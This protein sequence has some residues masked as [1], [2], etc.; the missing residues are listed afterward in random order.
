MTDQAIIKSIQEGE[1]S[2]DNREE[3]RKELLRNP[4]TIV[5]LDDDPTG[6]QTVHNVPVVTQWSEEVIENEVVK[7]PVFFILTNSR[8]LQAEE[9]KA[10]GTLIGQRLKKAA[11]KYDKKLLVISRSDSTLRGH[12]PN[13][14]TA[15]A[16]GLGWTRTKELLIPAFFEG[17]RYTFNDI[18]YVK[19]GEDFI[20]AGETPFA[21]DNTFGYKSSNLKEW[22]AEKTDGAISTNEV[23][24]LGLDLIQNHSI[25]K[26][27]DILNG[28]QHHF[29][30]NATSYNDLSTIAL[31]CLRSKGPFIFRTAASFVNAISGIEVKPLLQKEELFTKTNSTKGLVVVGSYVPKTTAQLTYLKKYSDAFFIELNVTELIKSTSVEK[32]L[33]KISA[34]IDDQIE[35]KKTVVLYTEREVIKGDTKEESLEIVNQVSRN[36]ITIIKNLKNKPGYILAKG[37]ITSS[38]IAVKALKV[39]RANTIGQVIKGVPVWQLG[40]EAKF[41]E[42]PYIIFPGNVGESDSLYNV[43]HKLS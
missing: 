14:V 41:P 25:E 9:A 40:S 28:D 33:R 36:L 31:A 8:A 6:T 1:K 27:C 5:I 3:I 13:E 43:I 29:I 4:R 7:S 16:E 11:V 22:I 32:E 34:K 42:L 20:P 19:E 21:R 30:I 2:K 18:H 26:V 12:Y 37:G 23:K 38:D 24:S 35:Q 17:G 10:L 15:L 39:T